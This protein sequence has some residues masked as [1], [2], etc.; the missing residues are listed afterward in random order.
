MAKEFLDYLVSIRQ[1]NVPYAVATVIEVIGSTSAKTGSRALIDQN[2]RVVTG[3]VGGGCAESTA[4]HAAQSSI[5]S[6][7]TSI[8][9]IDLDDEVWEQ[10]CLA[11]AICAFLSNH[12]F[13]SQPCGS[14]AT[15]QLLNIF[16]IWLI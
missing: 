1:Q 9:E 15:A 16:A 2:G 8:I 5:V 11:E 13:Q 3:W 12:L 10:V 7:E 6:G 4:C 14:W